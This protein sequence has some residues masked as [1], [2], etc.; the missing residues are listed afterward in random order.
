ME[1][2]SVKCG[3]VFRGFLW[4]LCFQFSIS[5]EG[6]E[7]KSKRLK[8]EGSLSILVELYVFDLREYKMQIAE[9]Q[10][11][12]ENNHFGHRRELS[13]VKQLLQFFIRIRMNFEVFVNVHALC[14]KG[15]QRL[16]K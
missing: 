16:L 1:S 6:G 12:C 13:K 3:R 7:W 5:E 2:V 9:R 15:E 10:V 4:G 8:E 11:Q 14:F